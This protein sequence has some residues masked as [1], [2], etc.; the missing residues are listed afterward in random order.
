MQENDTGRAKVNY[1]NGHLY[2]IG[3]GFDRH[4]G[5]PSSYYDCR[6][7][8]THH[9]VDIFKTFDLYFGPHPLTWTIPHPILIDWYWGALLHN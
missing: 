7:Y 6:T 8:L 1:M 3:S 4:H 2:I 9:N 5:A